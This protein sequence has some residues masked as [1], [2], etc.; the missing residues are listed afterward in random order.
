MKNVLTLLFQ[1]LGMLVRLARPNGYQTLVAENLLL[2]QQLLIHRRTQ[3]RA[4]NLSTIDRGLLG[5][6]ASF[7]S[8]R[9]LARASIVIRPATLL[10]FHKAL[11]QRKYHLLFSNQRNIQKPGPKGPDQNLIQAIIDIKLRNPRFGC[12]RIA[13]QINLAFGL[14]IDKDVVRRILTK[15]YKSDPK[16]K[17]PSWLTTLGHTKDSL[18]SLDLFRCESIHLKSHWVLVV[19][20]QCTRRIVGFAAHQGSPDGPALC[21]LFNRIASGKNLPQRLSS[22]NDPL[23]QYHQWKANLRI[24]DI[25][26]IK[27]IPYAP[28]SH[29]F[30]E[31]LIG[32]VRREL[33]DQTFFWNV[34]DL[35]NKLADY[36][37]Y[38]NLHR[39][40]DS[41]N[42]KTPV[43]TTFNRSSLDGFEWKS[44]CRGLF[45]LP[46]S[47]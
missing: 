40:H 20:D 6:L 30:V 31:R 44:Y 38:Y 3:Q 8:H 36:Q 25:V 19:M 28:M 24:R 35:E 21:R 5:F 45:Q 29:P 12:P 18:W 39:A 47:S 33:L 13:Q 7:L 15:H 32:S 34:H 10:K 23:F 9:R 41:L 43:T 2:K 4:P 22:D 16:N 42:G 46:T 27:S 11:V 17:G 1:L 37:Q 26:E 14:S